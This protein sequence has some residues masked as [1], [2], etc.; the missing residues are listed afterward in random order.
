MKI[1]LGFRWQVEVLGG[2][3]YRLTEN[4]KAQKHNYLKAF[5]YDQR[6][7]YPSDIL[8]DDPVLANFKYDRKSN[9]KPGQFNCFRLFSN[10]RNFA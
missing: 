1:A 8:K 5:S 9:Y 4:F 6:D 7:P 2:K 10:H 3:N